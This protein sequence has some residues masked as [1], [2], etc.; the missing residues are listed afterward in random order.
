MKRCGC[1]MDSALTTPQTI[2]NRPA[3]SSIGYRVGDFAS[4]R[5]TMLHAIAGEQELALWTARDETDYGIALIDMWAYLG[6]I[7][8]FYQE[9]IANEA[10]LRTAV[11]RESVMRLAALLDYRPSPGAAAVAHVAFFLDRGK[12]LQLPS[13]LRLQSIP[14]QNEKPQKFE[15][16]EAIA[17]D[18]ALNELR[19]HGVPVS[20]NPF[21]K[22]SSGGPLVQIPPDV[23]AGAALAVFDHH[24]LEAKSVSA[25]NGELAWSPAV[26]RNKFTPLTA[27][28]VVTARRFALYGSEVPTKTMVHTLTNSDPAGIIWTERETNFA[29]SNPAF[30]P[31]D[32]TVADIKAGARVLVTAPQG[33]R[34]TT[35][36]AVNTKPQTVTT[37]LTAQ[38][39]TAFGANVT[40][41]TLGLAVAARS[42]VGLTGNALDAYVV[43]DDGAIWT[44]RRE[45]AAWSDWRAL[46]GTS[47]THVAAAGSTVVA[48]DA[49]GVLYAFSGTEWTELGDG[50]DLITMHVSQTR[51]FLVA[52]GAG[53]RLFLR[54]TT[55]NGEWL[56]WET[57]DSPECDRVAATADTNGRIELF[58]RRIGVRDVWTR[59]ETAPNVWSAWT[60]LSGEIE[61]GALHAALNQ[62]GTVELLARGLD[63]AVWRRRRSGNNW[64]DWTSIGGWADRIDAGLDTQGRLCIF[65]RWNDRKL[66]TS[67]QTAANSNAY[68]NWS[69]ASESALDDLTVAP[70]FENAQHVFVEGGLTFALRKNG[71]WYNLGVPIWPIADRR[72]VSVIEVMGDPLPLATLRHPDVITGGPVAIPLTEL[73][74]IEKGRTIVL[75]D[76]THNAHLATVASTSIA[77]DHLLVSFTPGLT[78]PLDGRTAILH[79]N[80]ARVTHGE[81]VPAEV[82]GSGDASSRFQTFTLKK[83]PVTHVPQAGARN[84]VASTLEVRVDGVR[85]SETDSLLGRTATERVYTTSVDE[86]Q[87][88]TIQ[89]GGEPGARLPTGRNNVTARYRVGLGSEGNVRAGAIANLLDRPAG[90]KAARNPARAEGGA[91]PET[92]DLIRLNAPNTVRTFN[93]VVSL[94][95]FEDAA[96]EHA[97][98][99]KAR[100]TWSLEDYERVVRLTVAGEAGAVLSETALATIAADLDAKRDSNKP[101]RV[102]SHEN[103]PFLVTA[104]LQVDAAYL[105]DDVRRRAEEALTAFF[106]FDRLDLGLTIH[107]SEVYAALQNVTGVVAVRLDRLRRADGGAEVGDHIRIHPYEIATLATA[108]RVV[109]PQFEELG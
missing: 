39:L 37:K 82:A 88:T 63:S 69:S 55:Q 95:D 98:V 104:V 78:R 43:A 54:R 25:V 56:P 74:A 33:A 96:R 21:A 36:T 87:I 57:L 46:G 11:H 38:P 5:R 109:S 40:E 61:D 67:R 100:A 23:R 84:G 103:V 106:A 65:V 53:H 22:G 29:I 41:L 99:A 97:I 2:D 79:G 75:D 62:N 72:T 52:R 51:P 89:F 70:L 101:L 107:V 31:L 32:R 9:R 8:T 85:W 15:T 92:V 102:R 76:A 48:R 50:F 66:W 59:R 12:T 49:A 17:A 26:A 91:G 71:T 19:V 30:I 10:F 45:N 13:G 34:L 73:T 83:S 105:L 42:A 77:N 81:T 80:V 64:S 94:R 108:D 4:F 24:V 27:R 20:L 18:A 3:R 93:R 44:R 6:D 86:E 14:G 1:C 90:L 28:A 47:F 58:I 68:T 16:V 7:L 60:N 35:V